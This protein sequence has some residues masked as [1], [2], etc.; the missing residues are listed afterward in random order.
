MIDVVIVLLV[1]SF[2]DHYHRPTKRSF[3]KWIL[4]LVARTA[5]EWH[6][7]HQR[8]SPKYPMHRLR[9]RPQSMPTSSRPPFLW[10]SSC[11][12]SIGFSTR[13]PCTKRTTR[14][15]L[16]QLAATCNTHL[17]ECALRLGGR[18][19]DLVDHCCFRSNGDDVRLPRT[20]DPNQQELLLR[21]HATSWGE[22]NCRWL[23]KN[24]QRRIVCENLTVNPRQDRFKY[25]RTTHPC[26]WFLQRIERPPWEAT[27]TRMKTPSSSS[28]RDPKHCCIGEAEHRHSLEPSSLVPQEWPCPFRWLRFGE[29]HA[30]T[31]A[32]RSRAR[33][34]T[35]LVR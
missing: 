8:N 30:W 14:L 27:T 21:V 12:P 15:F 20:T 3:A 31:D 6:R 25:T 18:R 10:V 2:S 34:S 19:E 26:C 32:P 7:C 13:A 23:W 22:K 4:L 29:F 24:L 9:P 35:N 5:L 11:R 33:C 17:E 1:F 16:V 28:Y